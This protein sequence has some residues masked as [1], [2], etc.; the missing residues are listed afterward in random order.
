M[1][2]GSCFSIILQATPVGTFIFLVEPLKSDKLE[3]R[4]RTSASCL[5][6]NFLF[7]FICRC[8]LPIRLLRIRVYNRKLIGNYVVFIHPWFIFQFKI[9]YN[10]HQEPIYPYKIYGHAISKFCLR[11]SLLSYTHFLPNNHYTFT[12]L[13][14]I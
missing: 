6:F 1:V 11:W 13:L 9:I 3:A 10:I 12:T 14:K 2:G 4:Q 8:P 5:F 7:I